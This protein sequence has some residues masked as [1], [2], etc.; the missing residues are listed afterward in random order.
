MIDSERRVFGWGFNNDGN[1][2][3]ENYYIAVKKPIKIEE[4]DILDWKDIQCGGDC[5][6]IFFLFFIF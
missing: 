1:L 4:L 5:E 6:K 2:G 3:I